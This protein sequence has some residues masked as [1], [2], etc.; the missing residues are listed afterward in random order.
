METAAAQETVVSVARQSEDLV[1][2]VPEAPETPA[3][4]ESE[5]AVEEAPVVKDEIAE[6]PKAEVKRKR[7][8]SRKI[9]KAKGKNLTSRES[10]FAYF[11][12][13]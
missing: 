13:F 11:S 8:K 9:P 2:P 3:P 10:F 12:F 5:K 7:K 1:P 4:V 6:Q